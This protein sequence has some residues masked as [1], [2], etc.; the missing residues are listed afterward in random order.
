M[1]QRLNSFAA[2][3]VALF[4]L[5]SPLQPE[6][7]DPWEWG[8]MCSNPRVP[9]PEGKKGGTGAHRGEQKSRPATSVPRLTDLGI[10][11]FS[12]LALAEVG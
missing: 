11:K 6:D 7:L 8:A 12:I 2:R 3:R 5:N 4:S 9:D 10:T 1:R